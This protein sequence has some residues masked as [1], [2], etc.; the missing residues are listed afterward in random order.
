MVKFGGAENLLDVLTLY[1][2]LGFCRLG[3]KIQRRHF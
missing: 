3:L 2:I 1:E